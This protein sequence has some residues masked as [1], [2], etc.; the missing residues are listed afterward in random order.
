MHRIVAAAVVLALELFLQSSSTRAAYGAS[1][2]YAPMKVDNIRAQVLASLSDE[3]LTDEVRQKIDAIWNGADASAS[4]D[5]LLELV[6]RSF[7]MADSELRD[8]VH[9]CNSPQIGPIRSR[10]E[11]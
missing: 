3:Q 6:V 1:E 9:E 8:L 5:I 10:A 2:V 11:V 4:A 7:T